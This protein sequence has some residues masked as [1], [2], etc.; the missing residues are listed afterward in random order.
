M[1]NV[2]NIKFEDLVYRVFGA[3]AAD[4]VDVAV[5]VGFIIFIRL[6]HAHIFDSYM[7]RR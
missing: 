5:V 4:V 3:A 6:S 7:Y 1:Q 2:A